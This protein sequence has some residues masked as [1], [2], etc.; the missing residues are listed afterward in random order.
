MGT[1]EV[2]SAEV[3]GTSSSTAPGTAERVIFDLRNAG[4][5]RPGRTRDDRPAPDTAP[6]ATETPA[7]S[8]GAAPPSPLQ[9]RVVVVT[10]GASGTGREIALAFAA[11]GARVCVIGSDPAALRETV[12]LAGPN[13]AM[14][15]LQCDVGSVVEIEGVVDFIHRF[16]RPLD[17]IVHA[18]SIRVPGSLATGPVADLDEQYLVNVRGPYLLTQRLLDRLAEARG[19]IVLLRDV[20]GDDD[21]RHEHAQRDLVSTTIGAFADGLRREVGSAVAVSS[22]VVEGDV[23]PQTV[24]DAVMHVVGAP[25]SVEVGEVRLRAR[26]LHR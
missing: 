15:F 3:V 6:G 10:G 18:Q 9:G 13:A 2:I 20:V 14:V 23:P 17:C 7:E 22:I 16:D 1:T 24:C 11:A 8:T 4:A 21:P 26:P 25:D 5:T 19:R 12:E